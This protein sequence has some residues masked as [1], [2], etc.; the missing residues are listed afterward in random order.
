MISGEQ[1]ALMLLVQRPHNLRS[2]ALGLDTARG[3]VVQ[4]AKKEDGEPHPW[5]E[6]RLHAGHNRRHRNSL[7]PDLDLRAMGMMHVG[8]ST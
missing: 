2:I 5:P 8:R 1:P 7:F 6:S 4:L 3:A